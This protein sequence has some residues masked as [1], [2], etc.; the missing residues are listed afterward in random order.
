ADGLEAL[1]LAALGEYDLIL[2]NL[3]MPRLDGAAT[4]RLIRRLSHHYAHIP[5]ISL[6][7]ARQRVQG[8]VFTDYLEKPYMPEQLQNLL[9]QYLH[10]PV[11]SGLR[12]HIH[13]RLQKLSGQDQ[14]F[15]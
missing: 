13:E 5:I 11:Q 12:Q 15:R 10:S 3:N 4:V 7:A 14:V 2:M 9:Q 8:G 1:K 6:S